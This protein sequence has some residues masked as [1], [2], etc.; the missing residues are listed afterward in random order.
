M[1]DPALPL[2]QEALEVLNEAITATPNPEYVN[3]LTTCQSQIAAV[4]Q[5]MMAEYGP[6]GAGQGQ[7]AQ[8]PPQGGGFADPREAL[9][10][11]LGG[12]GF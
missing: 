4:Q 9:M 7:A 8:G 1:P 2:V 6:G 3:T 11:Q 5:K 12:G 10:A